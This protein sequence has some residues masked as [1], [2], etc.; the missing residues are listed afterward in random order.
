MVTSSGGP[1][2]HGDIY[3]S[4]I[5]IGNQDVTQRMHVSS[6]NQPKDRLTEAIA[7]LLAALDHLDLRAE[8]ESAVRQEAE[9][10]LVEARQQEP[11]VGRLRRF[12]TRIR[13]ALVPIAAGA[14]V[15]A[16]TGVTN[17]TAQLA[18]T[19]LADLQQALP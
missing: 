14:A 13:V 16:T 17:G 11:D 1:E 4:Q 2:F 9:A 10:A 18:Q 5:A 6:E 12:L 3:G 8:E 19:V 7:A 15:G